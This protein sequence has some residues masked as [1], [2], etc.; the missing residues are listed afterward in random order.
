[1]SNKLNQLLRVLALDPCP[2][3]FGYAV[4]EGPDR[5]IDWGV[6]GAREN[7]NARCLKEINRL[8]EQYRPDVLVVENYEGA[9]SRR[10]TRVQELI[11]DARELAVR[12]KLRVRALSRAQVR[13]AFAPARTKHQIANATAN[14]FLELGPHVPPYRKCWMSE[15]YRMSVFDAVGLGLA[16]FDSRSNQ[17]LAATAGIRQESGQAQSSRP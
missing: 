10:C 4:L 12:Q 2:R 5:L 14:R 1:M 15:D 17:G 9:G 11:A 16:F 6:R 8:I 3:G 13:H 7:K